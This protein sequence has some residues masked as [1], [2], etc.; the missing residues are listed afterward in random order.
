VIH[1]RLDPAA[2]APQVDHGLIVGR[3][4]D[5]AVLFHVIEQA[6]IDPGRN[7]LHLVGHIGVE[8]DRN[9]RDARLVLRIADLLPDWRE[10]GQL[11]EL[12]DQVF[13]AVCYR[14]LYPDTALWRESLP[15]CDAR[16][17]ASRC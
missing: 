5:H 1:K 11:V 7:K 6:G 8:D 4:V 15:H 13:V 12:R 17:S 16:A 14:S 2:H 3:D 9:A 10:V